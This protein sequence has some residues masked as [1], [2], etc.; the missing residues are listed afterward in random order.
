LVLRTREMTPD[1]KLRIEKNN[2]LYRYWY[3]RTVLLMWKVLSKLTST[4][5]KRETIISHMRKTFR[6][7][8]TS[9][10]LRT[11]EFVHCRQCFW[12]NFI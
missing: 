5:Q 12:Q 6:P 11:S 3:L 1:L 7:I 10:C 8:G 9:Q 4:N 2:L